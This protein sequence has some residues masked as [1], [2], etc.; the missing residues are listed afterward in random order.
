MQSD[1]N[2][3]S[4]LR[5]IYSKF[6]YDKLQTH[7]HTYT[8][9]VGLIY[10]QQVASKRVS[11]CL[12]WGRSQ[13]AS[14]VVALLN[15]VGQ[16]VKTNCISDGW[17][18]WGVCGEVWGPYK[19]CLLAISFDL[20]SQQHTHTHTCVPLFKEVP[21]KATTSSEW[22]R[23]N[24]PLRKWKLVKL[25]L[26]NVIVNVIGNTSVNLIIIIIIILN[27]INDVGR[28]QLWHN[29]R[30]SAC[31]VALIKEC[32]PKPNRIECGCKCE[33]MYMWICMWI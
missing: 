14:G 21:N 27:V 3:H 19:T 17:E 1:K 26:V 18:G 31:N 30:R 22:W 8:K 20:I 9:R 11:H 29:W 2:F 25:Q 7:T 4:G 33:Y 28:A 6:S 32:W 23:Q 13:P 15:V 16:S 24:R 10:A 5:L 12:L